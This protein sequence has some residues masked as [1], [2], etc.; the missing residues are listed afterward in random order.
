MRGSLGRA[1]PPVL[2]LVVCLS[3]AVVGGTFWAGH[4]QPSAA[5]P[6]T[7][8]GSVRVEAPAVP[9]P[10]V[11]ARLDRSRSAAFAAG[12]PRALA[13][14]Y[15]AGSPALRRDTVMLARLRAAG[16]HVEGLSLRT[17][18][19]R[20]VRDDADQV[21]LAVVDTMAPFLLRRSDGSV[22]QRR[23]GRGETCWS[24][25]LMTSRGRWRVLDVRRS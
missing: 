23:L 8:P 2:V 25:T 12:D 11:L 24:V 10:A 13:E 5:V 16:L 9:W 3:A 1:V 18:S 20:V 14:I 4:E 21:E 6:A 22:A 7:P 17:S 15:V 19:V